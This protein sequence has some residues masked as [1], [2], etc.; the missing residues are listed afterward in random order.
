VAKLINLMT[1]RAIA[2]VIS[3]RLLTAEARVRSR[4]VHVGCVVDKV[5]LGQISLRGLRFPSVSTIYRCSKFT[6]VCYHVGDKQCI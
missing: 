4:K 3:H 1:A 5:A 2:Q 6:Q